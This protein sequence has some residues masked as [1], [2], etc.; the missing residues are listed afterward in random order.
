MHYQMLF[1]SGLCALLTAFSFSSYS[2]LLPAFV[3][4]FAWARS[5]AVMPFSLAMVF[6]G[7]MQPLT[8]AIADRWG[9]RPVILGGVVCSAL[10][11]FILGTANSLWQIALGFGVCIGAANSACGSIMWA[12]IIAKWF[13]GARRAAA[14]GIVQAATPASPIVLAPLL[15]FCIGQY[16]W[17]VAS[18]GLGALLVLV[19]LPLAYI[20]VKDPPTTAGTTHGA[21]PAF[22]RG[23]WSAVCELVRRGPLRN[24]MVARFACGMSFLIIPHLA[25]A[26]TAT[27]LTPAEAA[28]AVALYGCAS[29]VGALLGGF[30]AD[31]WGRVPTL[32]VTY[33]LRGL[34]ALGMAIPMM[35]E[36][37]WFYLVVALS[38]GPVFAT[39]TINSVQMF[40][41][42]GPQRAGLILGVSFVMHQVAAAVGPYASGLL[43]DLTGTYRLAFAILGILMLLAML[44]AAFTHPSEGA[45]PRPALA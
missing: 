29:T 41:I 28:T 14:V 39:V 44:P 12:L 23:S 24:L 16:G 7:V 3:E 15:F 17:R 40:E 35:G 43:F 37:S 32:L 20:V 19:A 8:G 38:A 6:W 45:T 4:E 2:L 36:A 34:G 31:R 9:A 42:V 13:P 11:F 26:A 10:G 22:L 25:A 18:L 5:A 33:G 1:W 27:G 21:T 30:A